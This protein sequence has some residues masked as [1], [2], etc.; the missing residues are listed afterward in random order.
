MVIAEGSLSVVAR[1]KA[2]DQS[3][4]P[5]KVT[6]MADFMGTWNLPLPSGV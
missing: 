6:G 3:V 5:A 2:Q 1:T 4:G